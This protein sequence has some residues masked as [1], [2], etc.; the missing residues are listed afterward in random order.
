MAA[1]SEGAGIMRFGINR[2]NSVQIGTVALAQI[3]AIQALAVESGP[4]LNQNDRYKNL[5]LF[6]KVTQFVEKNYVDPVQN[7][8]LMNGAIKGMLETLDPHSNFLTPE[9]YRDMK[10]DTS[11]RFGGIGIEVGMKDD[12]LTVLAP[13]EDSPAWKAGILPGDR[14]VKINGESTKG[15]TLSEAIS[16]MRG[17]NGTSVVLTVFRKG[18]SA[19]KNI[20][21]KRQEIKIRSVRSEIMEPGY[22]YVRLS[23][24]NESAAKDVKQAIE[25]LE[26]KGKLQGL[27]FDLRMNPG[28]LLDQAVEVASLFI[29]EGVVV[30]TLGRDPSQKE[31]RTAR[32]GMA[33]KD[34][35]LLVLVNSSTASAAEIVAAAL[36]DHHRAMIV[37][38]TTFGKGSVQTIIDLGNEMGLKLTIA[39]YYSPSGTSIQEKGVVPDIFL[40]EYDP[41]LLAQARIRR[42]STR[43]RDLKGHLVNP[44][45]GRKTDDFTVE[46][47]K[48]KVKV[49]TKE[50]KG[51]SE[52]DEDSDDSGEM[53]PIRFN[54][55]EDYQT[56][57]ALR[58]LKSYEVFKRIRQ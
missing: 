45:K 35:P 32:K 56:Q 13:L 31:V 29:D 57:Q 15:Y 53:L 19:F 28:G 1:M 26:K 33:R 54:P 44:A 5:E 58:Y 43:E 47:F 22:G 48:E 38:D 10:I 8:V 30:S 55:K 9:V 20:S 17:K 23:S 14:I 46:E 37:G 27:V 49:S 4:V 25:G 3:L 50:R 42:E 11:G 21:L 6:Q 12:I 34:L 18:W 16:R 7:D 51:E 40:D 2:G 41:K 52:S 39:R 24:F 36:Q